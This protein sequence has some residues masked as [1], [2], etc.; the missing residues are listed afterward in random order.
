[1]DQRE[2]TGIPM[3]WTTAFNERQLLNRREVNYSVAKGHA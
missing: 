3:G 2:R 1:M